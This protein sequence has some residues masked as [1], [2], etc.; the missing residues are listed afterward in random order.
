MKISKLNIELINLIYIA[1]GSIIIGLGV[2]GFLAPNK[3]ATGGTSGLAIIFNHI[4][5]IPIG[6]WIMIINLPLLIIGG[7]YLGKKFAFKTTFSLICTSV[8]IDV[9]REIVKIKAFSDVHLLAT[10]YGGVL[11]GVGIAIVFKGDAAAGGGTIIARIVNHKRGTKPGTIILILDAVVVLLAAIVFKDLELALWAMISIFVAT[12]F[13]DLI[14]SGRKQN[15]IVHISA[16]ELNILKGV[17]YK[18]MGINA[19]I[20]EGVNPYQTEKSNI[21]YLS[22]NKNRIQTLK[23]IVENFD[24]NAYMIVLEATQVLGDEH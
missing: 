17:V 18:E 16:K 20:I 21:L 2:V 7:S 6:V 1:I 8:A 3:I 22:I 4:I 11:V 13:I 24:K 14:A 19:T 23:N 15:K 12:K 5:N 10:I 9:L